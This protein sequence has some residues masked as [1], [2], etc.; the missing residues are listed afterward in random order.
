MNT[1]KILAV[2]SIL[3]ISLVVNTSF[4]GEQNDSLYNDKWEKVESFAKKGQPQSALKIVDEI[5]KSAKNDK[6][7]AQIIKSLIYRISLQSSYQEDYIINS[8]NIFKAELQN[9]SIPEKQ[10]L[11]SLIAQLYHTYYNANR[12][13]INQRQILIDAKEN[14]INT[15][16]AV[17]LN[18]EIEKNYVASLKNEKEFKQ[19]P[20]DEYES[21]LVQGDSSNF[22]LWPSLYDLLANRALSY[23]SSSDI[24][25]SQIGNT[26]YTFRSDY[27]SST[28]DFINLKINPYS[29]PQTKT[30]NLFQRLLS[31][32][33]DQNNTEALI[34][35]DLKRL[36]YVYENSS[37]DKT[38][39]NYYIA[40]LKKLSNK[41][42][43][44][45]VYVSI[46]YELANQYEI[47]GNNYFPDFDKSNRYDLVLAD[48]ICKIALREFPDVYGSNNCRNLIEKINQ[49]NF[50]FEISSAHMPNQP[51]LSLVK[52]QNIDKLYFK[53][54]H[55]DAKANAN[56]NK[57]KEQLNLELKKKEIISW[58]QKL[59]QTID[60]RLHTVEIEVPKLSEGYYIIFVSDDSL[61]RTSQTIKYKP[62]WITN[63]SYI[64]NANKASGCTDMFTLNR[65]TG[66]R[67]SNVN[68]TIYKREYNNHSQT[69]DIKESKKITTDKNG[70]AKIESINNSNYGT[71]LFMF[72]KDGNQ[73]FSENYLNFYK[74]QK[75]SKSK[76][77]TFLFTDRAVYRPG[78]TVY[79]K[80][81][82]TEE[83]EGNV[84]LLKNYDT[85]I[86][87]INVSRKKISSPKLT[88]NNNGAFGGSFI[89]PIGGLN[90]QMTIKCKTGRVSFLVENY[91]LP[92]FEV[93]FDSISGQPKL[94]EFVTISGMATSYTGSAVDGA[95]V[96]YK[97][98]RHTVF[99]WPYYYG[100]KRWYPSNYNR[101][102]E[103]EVGETLTS[104]NGSFK[105]QFEAIAD[106]DIPA[107]TNPVFYYEISAEITDITGE[108]QTGNKS[109]RLGNNSVILTFEIPSNIELSAIN[110]QKILA[111]NLNGTEIN[112]NATISLYKLTPPERLLN[113]RRWSQPDFY[114]I[115]KDEFNQ[116]FPHAIFKN[117][118]DKNTWDKEKLFEKQI[119]INGQTSFKKD[120]L[121]ISMPGEYMIVAQGKDISGNRV[122]TKH[123]F[124][125]FSTTGKSMPGNMINWTALN[126][127]VAEPGEILKLSVGSA[128]KKSQI[129]YEIVNGNTIVERNWITVSRGQKTIEIPV[130][131]AYRG[132]FSINLSMVRFNRYYSKKLNVTVPFSN[133]KLD[134]KLNTFRNHLTPGSNE[135][136][137]VLISGQ[138]GQKLSAELLAGMYDAS[139]DI[140]RKNNWQ[141]KLYHTKRQASQWE[142][143]QFSALF[144]STFFEPE[145]KYYKTIRIEYPAVNWF[146][147]QFGGNNYFI[148][149]TMD[150]G[151]RKSEV[152][153]ESISPTKVNEKVVKEDTEQKEEIGI[154]NNEKEKAIIPL[155]KNFNE[156]AFFYP[157]LKTDSLGNVIF[158][159]DTPDALTEWKI[160]ML[161]Y[162]DD[163]KVGTLEKKIKSQKELMIIP[164]VPRFVRQGDTLVFTAKII[165]FT[166]NEIV[167]ETKIEFYDAL[168]LTPISIFDKGNPLSSIIDPKQSASVSWNLSIPDDVSM[169]GYRIT[170]STGTFSDGE[171]R[172]FP[173]LSNR[174]LV[175]NT[176]PMN[177][178][179]K[180]TA[181]FS[182][183]GLAQL[184]KQNSSIKN[185]RYTIEFTSNP[186]WYAVQAL[187]YLS[188]PSN[189][190]IVSLFNTYFANSLSSF[191][192]NSNPGIKSVFESW[193]HLTPDAFL[194]KL[195]KNQSLK[196]TLLA[197]TPWVLDAENETEQK[198]RIGLL[199]DVNNMS[200]QKEVLLT[201]LQ[202]AQLPTGAWPW[203]SGMREDRHT[204][205]TIVLGMAKLHHKG[206]LNLTGNN[207]RFHMIKKAVSWLDNKIVD[208]Y[209]KL[210]KNHKQSIEN[211]H[212]SSSQTQ[213]LY[214]RALLIDLIPIPK[215]SKEAFDYYIVQEKKYWLKQS[216]YLQGMIAL[217]L[218]KFGH[219][220]KS[221]AII[222]SLKERSLYNKEMGMYWRIDAGWRWYQ[223]PVETQ[224][225]MIE[226]MSKLDNNPTIIEQLKIWLLKQ[227]QTQHWQT[228]SATAEAIFALLMYGN[229]SL[230][231]NNLVDL[232]V[233]SHAID[234]NGNPDIQT[235]AGTGYFST[236]WSGA[237]ITKEFADISV[238]NTNNNIAWGAA[239]WQYFEDMDKVE[240]NNS[241]L[242]ISKK[243]F[244]EENTPEGTILV[245]LEPNQVLATGDK[246]VARLII[247][248]DRDIEYI[249]LKNMRA[250]TF[251][252]LD[253]ISGY[254]YEG[255][256]WYYKNITDVS[257]DFFIR[258][259]H[260]GTYVLEY[261]MFVTQEGDFTDGIA[262]IQSMYAPEFAAHSSGLR[263]KVAKE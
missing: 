197:S 88:T 58:E 26:S 237:E 12:W 171:E 247:T 48:S 49:V 38:N 116:K 9:A 60:H 182:F 137:S 263:I 183:N 73:L 243:L 148:Q 250:T 143:N 15:W 179:P 66:K 63:L 51:I 125:A 115:P 262:T 162:T 214:I 127:N 91:K 108:V 140:F 23:F 245:S 163:L 31:F 69:Y 19:I 210:K 151:M 199:F 14:E 44:H 229:N 153:N 93:L 147:Y 161:A 172:M 136:W 227:K 167:A 216:N 233:G 166:D 204:T 27:F 101:E 189:K 106:N 2:Y 190:S 59:P 201:K 173:V 5:Y 4:K 84:T 75:N 113:K 202:T 193:K 176:I 196:T 56:R 169:I 192:V 16:D 239:Y 195:E 64:T 180:S 257:T 36:Q 142:S 18:R 120:F 37:Q 208:D 235:E 6:N 223:A 226:T 114:I 99:P 39:R 152:V 209:N 156:T 80:G 95:S 215:K 188:E 164:N 25:L 34:D 129:M 46:A 194:S 124:T 241:P 252:P 109:L 251:E 30:L 29:S 77:K 256:L 128:A 213:Y 50:G 78:Q 87:F 224:A 119:N 130:I 92:T 260:K 150:G 41:Y 225:M 236:S 220:N 198:R 244:T 32:H 98:V 232:T 117:E 126:K 112:F 253:P 86:E 258:Y 154:S 165:N 8:I 47:S 134:I 181:N 33:L 53:I 118:D 158:S 68:I 170:S 254:M 111:T 144:S 160:L 157:N 21:I 90:G 259:L 67:I 57:R 110:N 45:P 1:L 97:V 248:T 145:P 261:P 184:G 206:V 240:C 221:E 121:D 230:E 249:H 28:P 122:E 174:I 211:Y 133:K 185:Y 71:F 146:G 203:F 62:I 149:G 231:S 40:A 107:K 242:S 81:I 178:N 159:F 238:T 43:N 255:G 177:V 131:E 135:E 217:T 138:N 52:F 139:L 94:G 100:N 3:I 102:I 222:R 187:P 10:I 212:I 96:K 200:N 42:N 132:N 54:V 74:Q 55:G 22:T 207:N 186:A 13:K 155:R 24:K 141:M 168:S 103:I 191:I 175:T 89:I 104:S 65:S 123:F 61:F 105:F 85:D 205:Q 83:R 234:V 72:E 82:V 246:V 17:T 20:L 218:N 70:Y 76:I 35:L 228:S 219:R 7:S 79:F 11:H